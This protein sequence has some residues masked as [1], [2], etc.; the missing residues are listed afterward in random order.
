VRGKATNEAHA[1]SIEGG[2]EDLQVVA[3]DAS[4]RRSFTD[5]FQEPEGACSLAELDNSRLHS[6]AK[7]DA[8]FDGVAHIVIHEILS[9]PYRLLILNQFQRDAIRILKVGDLD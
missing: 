8:Q 1:G 4:Q 5:F 9:I 7:G 2:A 3:E 6:Y